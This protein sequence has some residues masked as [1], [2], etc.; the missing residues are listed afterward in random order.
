M[1]KKK[2]KAARKKA[3]RR[4]KASSGEMVQQPAAPFQITPASY[5][6]MLASIKTRIETAQV[7]ASLAVNRELVLLYW[8]IGREILDRQSKEGWGAKVIDRLAADLR[9]AFPDVTGF[10]AR[11]LKYMRSF[12]ESTQSQHDN[13]QDR[14]ASHPAISRA[15]HYSVAV[16]A[17]GHEA[18]KRPGQS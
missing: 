4:A 6:D 14:E 10:S 16:V 13:A 1:A 2:V 11:N 3:T 18:P 7:K 17:T 12:G 9:A 15:A 8:S 5:A